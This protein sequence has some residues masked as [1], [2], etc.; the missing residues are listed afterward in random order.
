M[1]FWLV[2][3]AISLALSMLSVCTFMVQTHSRLKDL[4]SDMDYVFDELEEINPKL[5][6]SWES[7]E[8]EMKS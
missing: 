6:K 2:L 3:A 5:S 4:E 1:I 8:K 7:G